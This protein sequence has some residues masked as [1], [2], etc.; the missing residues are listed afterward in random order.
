MYAVFKRISQLNGLKC[1]GRR[2]LWRERRMDGLMEGK[3]D[4]YIA[5]VTKKIELPALLVWVPLLIVN[6]YRTNS[7]YWDR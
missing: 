1:Y 5:V 2:K 6:N 3:P 4:A 7:M